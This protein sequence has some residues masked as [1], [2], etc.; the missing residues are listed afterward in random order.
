MAHGASPQLHMKGVGVKYADVQNSRAKQRPESIW[1]AGAKQITGKSK[2]AESANAQ[3][4]VATQHGQRVEVAAEASV[5][6]VQKSPITGQALENP[7]SC[8]EALQFSQVR[9]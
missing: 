1:Q 9:H 8:A 3:G 2:G 5:V 6:L 4:A 7:D